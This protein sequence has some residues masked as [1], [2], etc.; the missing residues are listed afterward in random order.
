MS[1]KTEWWRI[2]HSD[3]ICVFVPVAHPEVSRLE[4]F[5]KEGTALTLSNIFKDKSTEP[6]K[7]TSSDAALDDPKTPSRTTRTTTINLLMEKSCDDK[8]RAIKPKIKER[9][10]LL[11]R[12][13]PAMTSESI[14]LRSLGWAKHEIEHRNRFQ[15]QEMRAQVTQSVWDLLFGANGFNLDTV[16]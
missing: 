6:R 16:G 10:Q 2:E 9:C 15:P 1:K 8:V 12:L 5:T 11:T 4:T 13:L 14:K 3:G 7:R